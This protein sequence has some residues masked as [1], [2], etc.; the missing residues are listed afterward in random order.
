VLD[1]CL[2]TPL[3]DNTCAW[4]LQSDGSWLRSDPG[5]EPAINAQESLRFQHED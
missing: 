1:E 2:L 3:A 4:H 5:E